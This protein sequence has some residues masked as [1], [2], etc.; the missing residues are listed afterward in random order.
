VKVLV[1]GGSGLIGSRLLSRLASRHEVIALVR[2]EPEPS[3]QPGV[4]FVRGDL[5]GSAL[6]QQLPDRIDG[7]V[8]LAQSK[9]YRDFP[10]GAEDVFLINVQSTFRLLDYARRAGASS[11][12]LASTGGLY[13]N[14]REPIPETAPL[15][16]SSPYLRSKRMAE[17][18]LE[19]YAEWFSTV[20]VRP[21]FVYGPGSGQMLVSRLAQRILD[22]QEIVVDGEPGQRINPIF[23]DDA[24]AAFEAALDLTGEEVV[25]VAGE[26]IVSVG[27]L[28]RRLG[29][30]LGRD[31]IVR[32]QGS[33][34]EGDLV[35]DTQR[36]RTVLGIEPA[37]PLSIGL[38]EVAR[39][40]ALPERS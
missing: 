31:A 6:P 2:R 33:G 1:T 4:R 12:V 11:F 15:L 8:H 21:F 24:A 34:P 13:G 22:E 32:H 35:A 36:M 14:S 5:A 3:T 17:L 18:L 40:L 10:E 26:E 20:A 39:W 9:R 23:V 7:V 29:D 16:P 27:D 37:T 28:A 19:D 25:N 30:A 38:A